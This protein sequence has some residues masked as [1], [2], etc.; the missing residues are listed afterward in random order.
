MTYMHEKDQGN[1]RMLCR[2]NGTHHKCSVVT[3]SDDFQ[4]MT[5]ADRC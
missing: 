1:M 4:L 3:S 5:A 2:S